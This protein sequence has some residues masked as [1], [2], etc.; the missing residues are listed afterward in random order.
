MFAVPWLVSV[1]HKQNRSRTPSQDE[2]FL[3][4]CPPLVFQGVSPVLT[5][6]GRSKCGPQ[7][8]H[9]L[10]SHMHLLLM[11]TQVT[12]MLNGHSGKAP[13][14]WRANN[15]RRSQ[16]ASSSVASKFPPASTIDTIW[17]IKN[18]LMTNK[19][20]NHKHRLKDIV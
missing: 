15:P 16:S 6:R 8:I 1:V 4:F 17:V 10:H 7:R 12:G 18:Y 2:S 13:L 5:P 3:T 14:G 20:N 11:T 19:I 9:R